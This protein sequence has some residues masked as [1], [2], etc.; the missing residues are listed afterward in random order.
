[1]P[2]YAQDPK[3]TQPST[4][5]KSTT[6]SGILSGHSRDASSIRNLQR[7]IGNQAVPRPSKET[8]VGAE[9]ESASIGNTHV[10]QDF[11]RIAVFPRPVRETQAGPEGNGPRA[12]V[13]EA[14]WSDRHSS[15]VA[16]Q[17]AGASERFARYKGSIV[18]ANPSGEV[19]D[20]EV[21]TG[22]G[23]PAPAPGATP[24][25]PPAPTAPAAPSG[26]CA[27]TA[28]PTYSPS[29]TIPV[30]RTG[31]RK[32]ATFNMAASF[33][34]A[35]GT[36]PPGRPSCCE[37]RQYIKWDTAFHTWRG[38]PP[39]GGF[40]S[41]ATA[42]T[43]YEDRDGTDAFRYG[44]RSGHGNPVAG[45][46]SEYKTGATQDQANGNTFCGRD[47]PGGPA[48]MTGKFQFQLKAVDTCNGSAVKA[49]SSIITIN[50]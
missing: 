40:P 47:T 34:T 10:G 19:S 50:W 33:G 3:A 42:N 5:A 16:V 46:G 31:T 37:I 32:S 7:T 21:V 41:S 2:A 23:T 14:L 1:M 12:S 22:N 15:R 49:S 39:H 48:S 24:P 6:P 26:Q 29:G 27:V 25:T 17:T 28:G 44:Y 20:T 9:A 11:S 18:T 4:R 36:S 8:L 13:S 30:T 35:P 43:W 38:G 45:C